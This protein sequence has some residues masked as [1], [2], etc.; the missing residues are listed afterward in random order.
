MVA[1]YDNRCDDVTY[2]LLWNDTIKSIFDEIKDFTEFRNVK[3]QLNV[4]TFRQRARRIKKQKRLEYL[5]A[6]K[7]EEDDEAK[8]KLKDIEF[9]ADAI[10]DEFKQII[11]EDAAE[12]HDVRELA[13]C[14]RTWRK[15]M[16]LENGE[17]MPQKGYEGLDGNLHKPSYPV[18]GRQDEQKGGERQKEGGGS[19]S[20]WGGRE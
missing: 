19:K 3:N 20:G 16:N 4:R 14:L 18:C 1:T 2:E 15:T 7:K 5:I 11:A 13:D 12:S 17:Q 10:N 8:K 6:S 9:S